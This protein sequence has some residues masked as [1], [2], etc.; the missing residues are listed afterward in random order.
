VFEG[1]ERTVTVQRGLPYV[2]ARES[3]P[4]RGREAR[5]RLPGRVRPVRADAHDLLQ[6]RPRVRTGV[7]AAGVGRELPLEHGDE[8]LVVADV[9]ADVRREEPPPCGARRPLQA[10]CPGGPPRVATPAARRRHYR[11]ARTVFSVLLGRM[12][13]AVFSGSGW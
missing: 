3:G 8:L 2:D 11:L 1:D 6:H 9:P 13:C 12:T 4:Q 5:Q 7:Q 10:E